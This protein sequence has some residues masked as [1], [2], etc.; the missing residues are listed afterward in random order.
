M[1]LIVVGVFKFA[2]RSWL[3]FGVVVGEELNQP[4]ITPAKVLLSEIS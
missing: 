4:A 3:G 2:Q 1:T